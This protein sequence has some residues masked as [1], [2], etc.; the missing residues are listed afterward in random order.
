MLERARIKFLV[1]V[2]NYEE[3][4][5]LDMPSAE[6]AKFLSKGKA[7]NVAARHKSDIVLGA[8]SF[9]VF[10]GQLLGKP[11]THERAVEMLT[12]LSGQYHSFI[13]GFTIID[14]E[15]GKEFSD[16]VET[17]VYFKKL[18]NTD[19]AN[20]LAKENVLNN[21]GAYII[22]NLGSV[23]VEKIDGS[24]SN[25]MSLPMSQVADALKTFGINFL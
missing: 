19:I 1:D 13:T 21:A 18:S 14:P 5:T 4:M 11:H 9:V 12:M 17:K 20:Y 3:D 15:S 6:L 16:A 8:D 7:Q 22:Q 25:V 10:N 2:S 23:L 24:F